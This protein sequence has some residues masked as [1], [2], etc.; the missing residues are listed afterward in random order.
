M[1]TFL[2]YPDLADSV[3]CLDNKR[4]GK[5]R[6]EAMQ[7]L[8]VL[9]GR[10]DGWKNHPAVKMW[11]GYTDCLHL[12]KDLCITEWIDRGFNN[13]MDYTSRYMAPDIDISRLTRLWTN[14]ALATNQRRRDNQN[15]G[16]NPLFPGWWGGEIHATHRSNL[17]RKD[18][19]HYSKFGW[20]ESDDLAYHWPTP[21]EPIQLVDQY[22]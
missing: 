3:M 9:E 20:N 4:L 14:E 19:D 16:I 22:I 6:V 10:R 18:A 8:N 7:I 2:P 5:Q 13:T 15:P 1:Q 11:T 21:L 17:L 12:Y